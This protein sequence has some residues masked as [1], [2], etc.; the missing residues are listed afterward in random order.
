MIGTT[1]VE[2]WTDKPQMCVCHIESFAVP[3]AAEIINIRK[4]DYEVLRVEWSMDA[5]GTLNQRLR[6]NVMLRLLPKPD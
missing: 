4:L 6:A 2:F 5:A 3:R 1:T